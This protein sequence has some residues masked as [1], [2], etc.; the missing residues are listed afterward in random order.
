MLYDDLTLLKL[1]PT[2]W[3]LDGIIPEEGFVGLYGAP[4]GGKS[5]IALDWAMCIAEGRAWLNLHS[6][7]QAPVIYVAAEGG[8]GIQK[9]VRAWMAQFGYSD[10][11]AIY[12]LLNPLYVR[13]A[14]MVERFLETLEEIG[15][16]PGMIVID[17]LARSFGGGEENASAD[18][19]EFVDQI[20]RL[21]KGRQM[22]ALVVHHTSATGTRER[23]HT[24]F[25]GG[26]DAMF[27]CTA[28]ND[29]DSGRILRIELK[30][31]KQKDGA[32]TPSIYL[33]PVDVLDSMVL[34]V[35]DPPE[36][37]GHQHKEPTPMRKVDMLKVL[38]NAEDGYTFTEWRLAADMPK[39]T[40]WRRLKQL[41]KDG[42][43]YRE[44]SKYYVYPTNHDIAELGSD[45]KA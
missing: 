22:A 42:A 39:A 5:F 3:L 31:D 2:K 10:I 29:K 25:R 43:I 1:P 4:S 35:T 17:T 7:K 12:W 13:E 14:G 15:V 45:E 18:M 9:R 16:W 44:N 37:K 27:K 26:L 34:E 8:R 38:A 19:G 20:T 23:G 36:K 30:N 28:E 33:R 41:E 24:S 32:N 21:A 40:C 6:C 11:P